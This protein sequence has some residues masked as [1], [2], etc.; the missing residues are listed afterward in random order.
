MNSPRQYDLPYDK[1]R[2]GQFEAIQHIRHS[3]KAVTILQAPTGSGKSGIGAALSYGED[4]VT[5]LTYTRSLQQQYGA[6]MPNSEVLYGMNAYPCDYIP[7]GN[8]TANHCQFPGEMHTCPAAERCKYL[9]RRERTKKSP[10]RIL[11]Y[12]YFFR[13]TWPHKMVSSFTYC[14]EAHSVPTALMDRM[15]LTVTPGELAGMRLS[16]VPSMVG[17]E[18]MRKMIISSW[19]FAISEEAQGMVKELDKKKFKSGKEHAL[20]NS[21]DLIYEKARLISMG[22]KREPD[23]FYVTASHEELKVFPLT[24]APF[25]W[26]AFGSQNRLVLASATIGSVSSFS[27]LL[28]IGKDNYDY[29]EVEPMYPPDADPVYYWG[30]APRISY[31]SSDAA[32]HRQVQMIL[33][34]EDK[35]SDRTPGLIHCSSKKTANML[36]E[37]LARRLGRRV[38]VPEDK[39]GTEYKMSTWEERLKAVPGTVTLAYSFHTGLDAPQVGWNVVQKVPYLPLDEYGEQILKNN[40]RMYSWLAATSIEQACGRIRRGKPE[41]YEVPGQPTRKFVAV[42]DNNFLRLQQ[43]YS[44]AFRA[45]MT[46]I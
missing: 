28:G 15:T 6:E 34:I 18:K 16:P 9:I 22:M 1:W 5:L 10:R 40:S 43:Y 19:L 3:D 32:Y 37:L 8:A 31:R 13:S 20:R 14:D 41:H 17:T 29:H 26:S 27:R 24:P 21:L 42:I 36:A 38:W 25:F 30:D 2:P 33:E 12:P 7:M 45:R 11:S 4:T 23:M 44:G 46:K 35:F 39:G